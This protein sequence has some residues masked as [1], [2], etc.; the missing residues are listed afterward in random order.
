MKYKMTTDRSIIKELAEHVVFEA[1]PGFSG[2]S[3]CYVDLESWKIYQAQRNRAWDP[4]SDDSV[5]VS[6]DDCF[7]L[8][9]VVASDWIDW[10]DEAR[11]LPSWDDIL[12]GY[13][14]ENEDARESNGDLADW[15]DFSEIVTWAQESDAWMDEISE[16]EKVGHEAAVDLVMSCVLESV[17]VE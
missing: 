4:W 16:Y 3:N 12:K 2:H 14:E 15:V 5:I 11:N 1:H 8:K 17:E 9:N 10:K 6:C 13:C 7:D